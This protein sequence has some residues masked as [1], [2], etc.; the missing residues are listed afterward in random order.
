MITLKQLQDEWAADSKIDEL[1]L[2][3][4]STK[5]PILHSKYL[6]HLTNFKLHQQKVESQRKLIRQY[7]WKYFRGEL[8]K[9]ELEVLKWEQYLGPQPLKN[10]MN[11]FIDSDSDMI[12][13]D[14]KIHYIKTCVF[15][16]ETIMKSL[17]SR[18]WDIKN[19]VE[20]EKFTNGSF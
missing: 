16:C 17:N 3:S 11:D 4:E 10:E 5:T 8:S 15:Q 1:N 18:T 19:A 7:K 13:L 14:D 2:G 6:N 20:W 9:E 12:K